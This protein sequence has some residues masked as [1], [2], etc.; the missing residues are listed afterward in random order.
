MSKFEIW[1]DT[2]ESKVF[3]LIRTKIKY[4]NVSLVKVEAQ[5]KG[6]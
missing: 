2:L 4:M 6:L 3:L 1:R 5:L